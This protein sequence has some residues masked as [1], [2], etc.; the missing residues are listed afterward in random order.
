MQIL[1]HKQRKEQQR[2]ERNLNRMITLREANDLIIKTE[3][4][5]SKRFEYLFTLCICG[6][7]SSE[8]YK[9]G[10]KRIHDVLSVFF[11]QIE[12]L[13]T[14]NISCEDMEQIALDLGI[15]ILK[16]DG[17]FQVDVSHY[18]PR[19]SEGNSKAI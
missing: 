17:I 9:F 6:I 13:V 10:K 14:G 11:G 18:L 4:D 8:P 16:K 15:K 3:K 19:R 5:L 1:N 2:I 12:A 7:L